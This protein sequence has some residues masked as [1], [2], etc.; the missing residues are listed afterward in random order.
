MNKKLLPAAAALLGVLVS[1][2]ASSA[3]ELSTLVDMLATTAGRIRVI[4]EAC[5]IAVDPMLQGQVIETLIS[6]PGLKISSVISQFDRRRR[7]EADMRGSKCYPEDVDALK[8]LNSIYEGEAAE[9]KILVAQKSS[10]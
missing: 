2:P 6:V 7:A 1:T 9:L 8:T 4:S 10:E 3:D 5:N